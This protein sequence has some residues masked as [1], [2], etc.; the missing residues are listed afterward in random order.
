MVIHSYPPAFSTPQ[1][2][3]LKYKHVRILV[4]RQANTA[5]NYIS[6]IKQLLQ[7]ILHI[8]TLVTMYKKC[9]LSSAALV[10]FLW[11]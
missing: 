7:Y 2:D 4:E 3:I 10:Y 5:V 1:I 9:F 11:S 8:S 6:I